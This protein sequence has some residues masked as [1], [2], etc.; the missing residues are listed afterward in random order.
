MNIHYFFF[1]MF[2]G[3]LIIDFFYH[4]IGIHSAE[5]LESTRVILKLTHLKLLTA[6]H[7]LHGLK[8]NV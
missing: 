1:R 4:N 7:L 3:I 2:G 5:V 8:K 6:L